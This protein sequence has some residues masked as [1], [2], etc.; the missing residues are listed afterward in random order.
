MPKREMFDDREWMLITLTDQSTINVNVDAA[1]IAS[2]K[3][4]FGETKT[5]EAVATVA[6]YNMVSRF[7]VALDI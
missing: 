2:L 5:V 3:N 1:V 4:L 7:L 6:A